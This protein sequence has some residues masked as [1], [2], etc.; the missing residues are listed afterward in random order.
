MSGELLTRDSVKNLL[1]GGDANQGFTSKHRGSY[2]HQN[3]L[4][5][6]SK[7]PELGG[8]VDKPYATI[9]RNEP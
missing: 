9:D 2:G 4:S 5:M 7:V 1:G 8:S 3:L 6:Q